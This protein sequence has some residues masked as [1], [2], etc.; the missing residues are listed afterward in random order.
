MKEDE[1]LPVDSGRQ[2]R[3]R[4][5]PDRK[6]REMRNAETILGLIR[7]RG[8]KGLPLERVYKLLFKEHLY[9]KAYRKFTETKGL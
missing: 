5:V 4:S 6:V 3:Y 9:L 1:S 7:E 2:G 8:S